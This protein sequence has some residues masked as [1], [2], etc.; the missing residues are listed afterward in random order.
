MSGSCQEALLEVQETLPDVPEGW[1]AFPD[2]RKAL[3]MCGR[4]SRLSGSGWETILNVRVA[5]LDI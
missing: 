5:L 1:E 3:W 4:P 2:V